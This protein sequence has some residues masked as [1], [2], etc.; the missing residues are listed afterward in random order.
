M[1][2]ELTVSLWRFADFTLLVCGIHFGQPAAILLYP[3]YF[4]CCINKDFFCDLVRNTW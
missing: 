3:F 4:L 1:N 2:E